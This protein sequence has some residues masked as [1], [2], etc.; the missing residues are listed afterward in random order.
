MAEQQKNSIF[1]QKSLETISSPEQLTDY[2]R[3]T[4]PSI[5]VILAAVILLLGGLFVWRTVGNLET[6]ANGTAVVENG[7]A[8]ILLID[9]DKGTVSSGMKFL[10]QN[11]TNTAD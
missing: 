2:P 6:I 11:R 5:W 4:N 7:T 1:R 3:V 8:Q 10:P 9:T